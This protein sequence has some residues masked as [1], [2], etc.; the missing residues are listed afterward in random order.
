MKMI[1]RRKG[2]KETVGVVFFPIRRGHKFDD[3]FGIFD[4]VPVAVD[5]GVA[6]E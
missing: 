1:E 4:H 5:D 6:I 2:I 3:R